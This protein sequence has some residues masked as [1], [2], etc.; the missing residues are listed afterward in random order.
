[1]VLVYT[2]NGDHGEAPDDLAPGETV[3]DRR[4]KEATGSAT[5]IGTHRVHWLDYADSGMTGWEQN[6]HTRAFVRADLDEA[7]TR[8]AH[9]LWQEQA[10]IVIGY[11]WHGGY[12]HPDHVK[13]HH[14][15][16]R[17]VELAGTPRLL[18]GTMNRDLMRRQL[19]QAKAAG[20]PTQEW[21]PDDPMDDG[22][23]MGTP[24]AEL[25]WACD[26]SDQLAVKRAALAAHASQTSDV[27][28][29][30]AMPEPVF[31]AVFGVEH[32]LEPGRPP[33]MRRS[34]F[35]DEA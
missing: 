32:Y 10:D 16:R 1:M 25:H 7:A 12:G 27:G 31:A 22:N 26:V 9:I 18:E 3:V 28:A 20:L 34:W 29:M 5:A 4:R 19:E 11:D 17:A 35:L 30:L 6:N 8:L 21:N 23:P 24:E 15:T 2:T 33:G 13:V 14:V